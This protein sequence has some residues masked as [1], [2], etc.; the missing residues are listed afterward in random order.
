MS[1]FVDTSALLALMVRD[2]ASHSDASAAWRTLQE[3]TACLLTTNYVVLEFLAI[4]QRRHGMPAVRIAL[5]SVLPI[6]SVFW[7]DQR[8]HEMAAESLLA[9]NRRDLSMVDCTSFATMR[10]LGIERVFSLDPHFAEQ[11]FDP[12]P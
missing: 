1:V 7:V 2:D 12:V 5:D 4:L 3:E 8:T 11:G 9:A 6:L 10:Q